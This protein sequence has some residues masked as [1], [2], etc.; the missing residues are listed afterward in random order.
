M[1][2]FLKQGKWWID[3]YEGGRRHRKKT[4]ARTKSQAKRLLEQVRAKI[5]PRDLGVFDPKVKCAE[6]VTR[7]LEARKGARAEATQRRAVQAL[8]NFFT[9]CPVK[10]VMKLTPELF[11]TYAS[12]RKRQGAS[13]RTINL[14]LTNL[15]TCLNWGVKN[16]IIPLNPLAHADRLKG[17]SSGRLRFLS[18]D[19]IGRLLKAADSTVYHDMFYVFLRTGMRKGELTHLRWED[20]DFDHGLMRIGAHA[21]EHG[22]DDT[23]SH[24]ERHIPMDED[25][26]EVIARQPRRPGCHHVFSTGNGTI[27]IN[28][29]LRELKRHAKK[30]GIEGVTL[31]TLR[32]TFASHLVM[33]GADLPSVK[34]LLGHSTIQMTMRYAHLGREHLR[35]AA[36]RMKVPNFRKG[37]RVTAG[38]GFK[39]AAAK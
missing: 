20:V 19:E 34:E 23:K 21:D 39:R 12:H 24:R 37:A 13:V 30:A 9:W 33:S 36:A 29:L 1:G 11:E 2:V 6:L 31:H 14:E 15:R 28:N 8:R 5:V 22:R 26:A 18:E 10:N 32:H 3:W 16:K 7:H 27:R 38:P 4:G 35:E 25:L 17:E